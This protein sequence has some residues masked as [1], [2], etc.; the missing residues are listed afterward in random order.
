MRV[1]ATALFM[2]AAI[3]SAGAADLSRPYPRVAI[4][5][6]DVVVRPVRRII[7]TR[8][9]CVRCSRLPL[10]GL[11]EPVVAQV[12]LGGLRKACPPAV[13]YTVQEDVVLRV[14]G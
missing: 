1:L 3:P 12:P 14:K 13:E 8:Q 6:H 9:V 4:E 5:E 2:L 11:R 10:G 7:K